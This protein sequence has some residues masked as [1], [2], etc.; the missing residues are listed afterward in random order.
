MKLNSEPMALLA[1][2]AVALAKVPSVAS[3]WSSRVSRIRVPINEDN[4]KVGNAR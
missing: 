4:R 1:I 2:C 3:T